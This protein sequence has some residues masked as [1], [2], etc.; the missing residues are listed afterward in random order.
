MIQMGLKWK[1]NRPHTHHS[2]FSPKGSWWDS[3]LVN[4][5]NIQMCILLL[6][7][8]GG[9]IIALLNFVFWLGLVYLGNL[10]QIRKFTYIT[11]FIFPFIITFKNANF[12]GGNH[13]HDSIQEVLKGLLQWSSPS[14]P[15]INCP[16]FGFFVPQ[17][18][19][20]VWFLFA[21]TYKHTLFLM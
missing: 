19:I 17:A 1:T 12:W 13:S 9:C 8:K 18:P 4:P 15:F 21:G 6:V 7:F 10:F 11:Y 2:Y 16:I 5:W 3:F 14:S 20:D